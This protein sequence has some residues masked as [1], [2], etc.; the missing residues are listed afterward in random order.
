MTL[1]DNT[2]KNRYF[3]HSF[4]RPKTCES[5]EDT[6]NRALGILSLMKKVGLILAPEPVVWD[7]GILGGG[8]KPIV[9]LQRRASFTELDISEL[10][11]HSQTFGP[12]SLA[13]DIG[14]L[15]NAGAVPVIYVPKGDCNDPVSWLA[16]FCVNAV[17][18]TKYVLSHLNDLKKI[19]DPENL[20]K[21]VGMP[22]DPS[23]VLELRNTDAAGKTVAEYKIPLVKIREFLQYVGFNNIP[24]DHSAAALG[25]Y[26]N[27][28]YP[29][30]NPYK[31]DLLGYYRQR[32][33]R[34]TST[35]FSIKG[36][37]ITRELSQSEADELERAD[38]DFWKRE[39]AIEGV[40]KPRLA[41][42]LVYDPK[43]GWN[44]FDVVKKVIGPKK[45]IDRIRTIVGTDVDVD[46][47]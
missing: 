12:L 21:Q 37:P 8:A 42:A 6:L 34:L 29:T 41:F 32:E 40:S 33:W 35:D 18:H 43:P 30:D 10:P 45:A 46:A 11:S 16:T 22:V 38:P 7:M 24:F 13:F 23:C 31:N 28:F 26:L 17:Y 1:A 20:C 9:L 27:I 4:S 44:L 25:V 14:A 47:Y 19:S 5:P 2:T 39:L 15:R 3:F 36:R